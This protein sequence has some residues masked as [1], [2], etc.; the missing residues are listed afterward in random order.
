MRAAYLGRR[1]TTWAMGM[2]RSPPQVGGWS[3]PGA[4]LALRPL[5]V[6]LAL[7]PR[8]SAR[9][10]LMSVPCD[11]RSLRTSS[12]SGWQRQPPTMAATVMPRQAQPRPCPVVPR[13][14]AHHASPDAAA[15]LPAARSAALLWSGGAPERAACSRA[16]VLQS[17][18]APERPCSR[19]PVLQASRESQCR[20]GRCIPDSHTARRTPGGLGSGNYSASAYV[21]PSARAARRTPRVAQSPVLAGDYCAVNCWPLQACAV[22]RVR[23]CVC[24]CVVCATCGW[25]V[26]A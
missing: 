15:L 22:P 13:R 7:H 9:T 14:S 11:L 5:R 21:G 6:A 12:S 20:D 8:R 4:R 24:A 10:G 16:P 2:A 26:S 25:L 17:A 23:A 18:R 3:A 1:V 19:A